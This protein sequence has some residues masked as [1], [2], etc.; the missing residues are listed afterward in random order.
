MIYLLYK[1]DVWHTNASKEL[2][3]IGTTLYNALTLANEQAKKEGEPEL[4]E[5][6]YNFLRDIYQTQDYSGV[7][8][9]L[10]EKT[11]TNKLL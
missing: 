2:I 1:T 3:G 11:E 9:F 5:Y 10:I 4:S 7:G 6:T 8:E